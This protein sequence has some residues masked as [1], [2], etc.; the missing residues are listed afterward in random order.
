MPSD[1]GPMFPDPAP[2]ENG[3][4][5]ISVRDGFAMA[6]SRN[7]HLTQEGN[8][9]T[10]IWI[11]G[12]AQVLTDEKL[13]RDHIDYDEGTAESMANTMFMDIDDV[14]VGVQVDIRA[15]GKMLWVAV[16]GVTVLRICQIPLLGL[17]DCRNEGKAK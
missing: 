2:S 16:D 7:A 14:K 10:A 6:I 1:G 17:N 13:R 12:F 3:W 15:D 8:V 9:D 4:S 5:G 11:Y